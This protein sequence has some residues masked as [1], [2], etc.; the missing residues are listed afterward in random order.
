MAITRITQN[1]MS[2]RSNLSLQTALS[3]LAKTQE[4]L[5]TGRV[6]NRPSDSPADTTSAMR[7]RAKLADHEQYARNIT[8][9]QGWLS[10]LDTALQT[11]LHTVSRATD[12]SIQAI[13]GTNQGAQ[14]RNAIA[15]EIDQLRDSL[16][17]TAN[18]TYLGRPVF[19]GITAGDVAYDASGTYVG[20][21]GTVERTIA[22]GV[23]VPVNVDGPTAFG[24]PGSDVF[25]D[26][27][28]LSNALRL[29]D[30]ATV[31]AK[32]GSL[33]AAHGRLTTTLSDVGV[34]ASRLD[35]ADQ[36]LLDSKLQMSTSLSELENVDIAQATMDLKM[37][38]LAYQTAL[39]STA[40][41]VQ[42]SLSD[43]LR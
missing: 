23:K 20:T 29:G 43:F 12:L 32:M 22:P 28:D 15:I 2:A 16:V 19:G 24:T 14:G 39:S 25:Q 38:E 7:L 6:L 10:S 3:R 33:Q 5:T 37:Q 42:P 41:L 40:R 35:K 26:L 1:M 18:T 36:T 17:S 11:A 30:M 34:R 8:N 13:N 21:P 4:Q 31:Q 9:G 27:T